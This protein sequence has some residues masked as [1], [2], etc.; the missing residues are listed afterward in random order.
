[1]LLAELLDARSAS[2]QQQQPNSAVP[3]AHGGVLLSKG[4]HSTP[5]QPDS[6]VLRTP[7]GVLLS[8][9]THSTAGVI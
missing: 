6:A 3:G 9:G 7:G 5:Q 1:M 4:T 2:C 8:Q